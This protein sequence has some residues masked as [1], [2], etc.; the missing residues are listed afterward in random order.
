MNDYGSLIWSDF[1]HHQ[2]NNLKLSLRKYSLNDVCVIFNV[3]S[4]FDHEVFVFT[5]S[6]IYPIYIFE[7][8]IFN[9]GFF[10][11]LVIIA[12]PPPFTL[13]AV[14]QVYRNYKLLILH[15]ACMW[16]VMVQLQAV[17]LPYLLP[18]VAYT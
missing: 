4:R 8:R 15:S 9:V 13:H 18:V 5:M 7:R 2:T 3:G 10:Y 16:S 6:G 12:L 14:S 11:L 17:S 1:E